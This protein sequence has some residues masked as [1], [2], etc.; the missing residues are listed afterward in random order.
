M[1]RP[2]FKEC[3]LSKPVP[4]IVPVFKKP[5]QVE[6]CKAAL[7]AQTVPTE[8]W[9][10][11]NN[12]DNI[13]YTKAQNKGLRW[14]IK[15][16]CEFAL[17]G[18]QDVYLRPNMV[19]VF[20]QFMR[21]HPRCA[22]AGPKQLLASNEDVI[23]H[24]GGTIVYPAGHHRHGLVSKG[25]QAVNSKVPWVNGAC[26]MARIE[27]LTEFGLMDENM[28]MLGSDSDWCYTARARGWEVWYVADAVCIHEVG[29]SNR[30]G[31]PELMRLFQADMGYFRDKWI[32]SALF[33]RLA[34]EFVYDPSGNKKIGAM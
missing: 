6:K 28:L 2:D 16:G 26:I 25:D 19:E 24:A 29:V 3:E 22:L 31:A 5:D 21:D 23:V 15:E 14:A 32:G 12:V 30:G 8:P 34:T 17:C 27:A 33:A 7:A 9:I 10:W 1:M 18:T 20:V 4:Y 13:Y 11:D